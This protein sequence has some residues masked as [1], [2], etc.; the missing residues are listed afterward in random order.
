MSQVIGNKLH[1]KHN[2]EETKIMETVGLSGPEENL[3]LYSSSKADPSI[4]H[5]SP[6]FHTLTM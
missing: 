4:P 5:L 3:G 1:P 2:T 6:P